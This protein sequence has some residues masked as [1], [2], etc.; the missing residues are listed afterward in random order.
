MKNLPPLPSLRSF[1]AVARLGS[2][3]LAA[4]ELHVT[5]SAIS[6][7]I[8]LLEQRI[9]LT[10]F[11]RE[12]RGL[13]L[14][15]NGRLYALQI[16][17]ALEDIG[18]ATRLVQQRPGL[19]ELV[20]AV[21]PSFGLNWL[22]P[23]LPSFQARFP[24][25][26]LRVKAG[27]LLQ[28][29]RHE[30]VDVAIRMGKGNWEGLLQQKLFDDELLLVASPHFNGGKLPRSAGEALQLPLI[31]SGESWLRWCE[32]AGVPEPGADSG[33]W[34]NDSNLLMEAV[35][36]KQGI[37]LERRSLVEGALQRGEL[38]QLTDISVPY[39]YPYW[40][41]WPPSEQGEQKQQDFAQWLA[42]E[43]NRYVEELP[44]QRCPYSPFTA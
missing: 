42:E 36:L 13:R 11:I 19:D 35:R 21:L 39:D 41:V 18:E 12:G 25:Y 37:A 43:V 32:K 6:Q 27:L 44:H 30:A 3:T 17:H 24:H 2:I 33:L 34:I 16:R 15:E 23:R 22:V 1:E 20:I 5:H 40:L 28:D 7:Q 10:L 38:V 31:R 9:G 4:T 29:L 14:N 8:K 26:R